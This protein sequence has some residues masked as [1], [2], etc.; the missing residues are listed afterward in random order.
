MGRSGFYAC[1]ILDNHVPQ[2]MESLTK[3]KISK[4]DGGFEESKYMQLEKFTKLY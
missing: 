2:H 3:K 1:S 4:K